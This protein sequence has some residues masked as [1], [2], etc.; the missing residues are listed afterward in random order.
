VD[1]TGTEDVGI[2]MADAVNSKAEEGKAED[3]VALRPRVVSMDLVA[4]VVCRMAYNM[5]FGI[6]RD[7]RSVVDKATVHEVYLL[8][9]WNPVRY[10]PLPCV[11]LPS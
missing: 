10:S 2:D 8:K 11:C 4:P 6:E 5:A 9:P 3:R 1:R 7:G